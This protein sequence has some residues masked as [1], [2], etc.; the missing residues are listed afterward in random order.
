MRINI[1]NYVIYAMLYMK[2]VKR[3]NPKSSYHRDEILFCVT[4][5]SVSI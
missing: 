5:Y 4:F 2:V 1:I 3:V